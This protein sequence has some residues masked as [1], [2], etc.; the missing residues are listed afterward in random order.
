MVKS[1]EAAVLKEWLSEPGE[2]ALLDVR[3]I[4]QYAQGHPFFA[5]PVPYSRL[6]IDLPRLVPRKSTRTVLLDAGD[7]VAERAAGRAAALGY[8]DVYVLKDGAAG[9]KVSAVPPKLPA[10]IVSSG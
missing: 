5:I 7:G 8:G 9:W 10:S 3:E 4:G 6:E 2:I 1:V